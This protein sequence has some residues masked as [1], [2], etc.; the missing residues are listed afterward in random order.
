MEYSNSLKAKSVYI[1][2]FF[3]FPL[4]TFFMKLFYLAFFT[5]NCLH[6]EVHS[7]VIIMA[8]ALYT[9]LEVRGIV[10]EATAEP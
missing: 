3:L 6:F 1:S 7:S 2:D 8:M 9:L 4:I 5:V 10:T